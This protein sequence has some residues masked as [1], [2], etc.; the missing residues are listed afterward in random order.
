MEPTFNAISVSPTSTAPTIEP[1]LNPSAL[2]VYSFTLTLEGSFADLQ[3][4]LTSQSKTCSELAIP[5]IQTAMKADEFAVLLE[6]TIVVNGCSAGSI[7][8]DFDLE[9]SNEGVLKLAAS[10]L[11]SATSVLDEERSLSLNVLEIVEVSATTAIPTATPVVSTAASSSFLG[12]SIGLSIIIIFAI[13]F[14]VVI[15]LLIVVLIKRGK[16]KKDF[17]RNQSNIAME[18]GSNGAIASTDFNSRDGLVENETGNV[19]PID[20]DEN[21]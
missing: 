10:N 12:S 7:V 14:V 1:T 6:I 11:N 20:I 13:L 21:N 16:S 18:M 3:S 9:H 19:V 17:G 8:L 5:I 4:Y 15:I 2:I